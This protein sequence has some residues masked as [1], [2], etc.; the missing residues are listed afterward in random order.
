[1]I[2][3]GVNIAGVDVDLPEF[4]FT[5]LSTILMAMLGMSGL[6]SYEK[7]KGVSRDN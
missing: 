3:F 5:Q 2:Q 6:R 1:M 7:I 4:D